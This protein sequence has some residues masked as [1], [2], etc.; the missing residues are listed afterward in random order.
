MV[1]PKCYRILGPMRDEAQLVPNARLAPLCQLPPLC[2]NARTK[3]G[4]GGLEAPEVARQLQSAVAADNVS[5]QRAQLAVQAHPQHFLLR[6][7]RG[8]DGPPRRRRGG[9]LGGLH[10]LPPCRAEQ[11]ILV[12]TLQP[13]ITALG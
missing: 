6:W 7:L 8:H 5:S 11:D 12:C 3:P 10:L 4:P 2:I 1:D 9:A 13:T